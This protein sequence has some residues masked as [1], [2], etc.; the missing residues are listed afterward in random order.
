MDTQQHR[1]LL[2]ARQTQGIPHVS[3][4]SLCYQCDIGG[5]PPAG[6]GSGLQ[7]HSGSYSNSDSPSKRS[8]P[9]CDRCY[10][11]NTQL[12]RIDLATTYFKCVPLCLDLARSLALSWP[13]RQALGW[14][15]S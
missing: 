3:Q 2:S 14:W 6:A 5:E 15:H 13:V 1:F 8:L 9:K 12:H 4:C 11:C 10:G 7:A